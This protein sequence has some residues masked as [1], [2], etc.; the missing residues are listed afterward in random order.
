[1][2]IKKLHSQNYFKTYNT[3]IDTKAYDSKLTVDS[4]LVLCERS[5]DFE[6]LSSIASD[7]STKIYKTHIEEAIYYALLAKDKYPS[8]KI[9]DPTFA[10]LRFR[11][12]FFYSQ[13][14][15]YQKSNE[16]YL[17]IIKEGTNP[18]RIAQSYSELGLYYSIQGDYF[19][20]VDYYKK[21]IFLLEKQHNY[22]DIVKQYINL[23]VVY[24]NQNSDASFLKKKEMLDSALAL[25]TKTT[26]STRDK[27]YIYTGY[28]TF[29]TRKNTFDFEKARK[30]HSE[31]LKHLNK[32]GNT[33]Y[34]CDIYPNI[35][36][37][38]LLAKKDSALYYIQKTIKECNDS[39][40]QAVSKHHLS[41]YY[42]HLGDL[43][44]ALIYIQESLTI[45]TGK[46]NKRN[47]NLRINDLREI[48]SKI[49]VLLAFIEKATVLEA[50]YEI[51]KD[52]QDLSAALD[53]ILIADML[54]DLIE[55]ES[56]EEKSRLHWRKEASQF[57]AQGV[58]ISK[59]LNKA[60]IAFY[61]I[62]KN[63]ALLLTAGITSKIK[64]EL[65]PKHLKERKY[66]LKRAILNL[67][68]EIDAKHLNIKDNQNELFNLKVNY[69][70]LEDS[71]L[72]VLPSYAN[73]LALEEN[74][75]TL[76]EAQ[77]S[78]KKTQA[79]I[80]YIWG[81]DKDN[82]D[83]VFGVYIDS[84]HSEIFEIKSPQLL[85]K[86]ISQ[87]RAS[88]S[89]PI[90]TT[91]EQKIYNSSARALFDLLFPTQSIKNAIK[92]KE[93]LIVP[94][95]ELQYVSFDALLTSDKPSQ[96]L[97]KTNK[98]DYCYSLSFLKNNKKIKRVHSKE[99]VSFA[100]VN[101]LKNRLKKLHNSDS[102]IQSIEEMINGVSFIGSTAT[103]DNFLKNS[104]NTKIVHLATHADASSHPWIAF[105]D[106]TLQVHELYSY[107]N[108]AELVVLS[109]CNTTIGE[110]APGEGVM[111][112]ARGFFYAG[113]N[114]VVSSLWETNDKSTSEIMTSFYKHL[115]A[116]NSKSEALH[117]AKLDYISSHS[118]SQQSPYY[119]ATFILI[120]ERENILFKNYF[121]EIFIGVIIL[122]I[123][124]LFFLVKKNNKT[125]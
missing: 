59:S 88:T 21:A 9:Y 44:R 98:I 45:S 20:A 41:Q 49:D 60:G 25:E 69:E 121:S 115:K 68:N 58:R 29:Y 36:D 65:L 67:E 109:A 30:Y 5:K 86:F 63:K 53:N 110:I 93:L 47:T 13:V 79:I 99:L 77:Q 108:N 111:S 38:Y 10:T 14:Q 31:N 11:L 46:V 24:H 22:D 62:E 37:L 104:H 90:E 70:N 75:I 101:F 95:G 16:Q 78:L 42:K 32:T 43:D 114:T 96:Y 122:L 50:Q 100:P 92:A 1:M 125:G 12:G 8:S 39:K 84:N 19:K 26:I 18:Q 33:D 106:N 73:S 3:E 120:G 74:L 83:A 89:K 113:A 51:S 85:R 40:S 80:S 55:E 7:F 35:S 57:Y 66:N 123:A 102:E 119:W 117:R 71:L 6:G 118:L 112:L 52:P 76:K 15:D 124:F 82:M 116:G 107:K 23:S 54:I 28:A 61:F 72:T 91:A 87:Y 48:M 17:S 34:I 27:S 103:K 94:D 56:Q 105:Y 81:T 64:N 4:L 97:I 2:I